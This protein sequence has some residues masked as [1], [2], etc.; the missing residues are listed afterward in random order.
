MGPFQIFPSISP[1]FGWFGL[2]MVG[3]VSSY[4]LNMDGKWSLNSFL[5][6]SS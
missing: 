6:A 2:F 4:T 5:L 1:F 3:R